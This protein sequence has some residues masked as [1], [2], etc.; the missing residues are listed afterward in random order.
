MSKEESLDLSKLPSHLKLHLL[1]IINQPKEKPKTQKKAISVPVSQDEISFV[2]KIAQDIQNNG[3]FYKDDFLNED[4]ANVILQEIKT[5]E[6]K[7]SLKAAGMGSGIATVVNTE[8]RGDLHCWLNDT[9][10]PTNMKVA[11]SQLK[12]IV[13]AFNHEFGTEFNKTSIQ[14]AVYQGGGRRYKRHADASPFFSTNRKITCLLYFNKNLVGGNLKL[15]RKERSFE[16]EGLY[17]GNENEIEI[18]PKFNRLVVFPS[19]MYHEVLPAY[20]NRYSM[21]VNFLIWNINRN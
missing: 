16:N 5:L 21:V 13:D 10:T 19:D 14:V 2:Q 20:S 6:E 11:V 4:L 9:T 18:E 1:S 7:G 15:Y 8:D 3:F 17:Y 12:K